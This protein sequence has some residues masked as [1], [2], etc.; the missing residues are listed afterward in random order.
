MQGAI[1]TRH[2]GENEDEAAGREDV[3][4]KHKRIVPVCLERSLQRG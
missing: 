2:P 4:N 1:Q 3:P